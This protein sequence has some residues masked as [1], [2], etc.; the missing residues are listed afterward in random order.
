MAIKGKYDW[1]GLSLTECYIRIEE[2]FGNP[3]EGF[4]IVAGLYADQAA[5]TAPNHKQNILTTTTL[6]LFDANPQVNLF[7]LGYDQLKQRTE[8]LTF[9]D[10]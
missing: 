8:F 9:K 2:L 10:C 3:R 4:S 1:R 6:N 7:A 5:A